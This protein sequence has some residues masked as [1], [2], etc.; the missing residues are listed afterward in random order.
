MALGMHRQG[1]N[2]K[3]RKQTSVIVGTVMSVHAPAAGQVVHGLLP[4]DHPF[5]QHPGLA[6]ATEDNLQVCL[7]AA[8]QAQV[9]PERTPLSGN[10]EVGETFIPCHAKEEAAAAEIIVIGA[11]QPD[12]TGREPLP[13]LSRRRASVSGKRE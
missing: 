7:A 1:D 11:L 3:C 2:P 8:A 10:V 5:E 4:D 13:I 9:N 12:P 6:A